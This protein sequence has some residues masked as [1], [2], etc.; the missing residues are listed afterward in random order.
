[1]ATIGTSELANHLGISRQRV[2]ELGRLGKI[3]RV[4]DGGWD[5]EDVRR[6]LGRRLDPQQ[7]AKSRNT[8]GSIPSNPFEQRAEQDPPI[9]G[10][11]NAHELFNR[12]RAAKEIA[13]AKSMQLDLKQRE[14]QLLDYDDVKHTWGSVFVRF[15][16]SLLYVPGRLARKV[17]VCSDEAEC[18]Q[19][20]EDELVALLNILSETR[21]DN[22]A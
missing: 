5:L 1:M 10:G 14:G 18:R 13:A 17:A 16:N 7:Q 20:I 6:Q 8:G 4:A 2:N 22:V 12:A 9:G 3:H 15:K 11:G 21:F 19:L